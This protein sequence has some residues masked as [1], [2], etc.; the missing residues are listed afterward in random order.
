MSL[1]N[2]QREWEVFATLGKPGIGAVREVMRDHLLVHVEG[3]GE[4]PVTADQI[5]EAH[6]GKVMLDMDAL[7]DELRAAIAHAHDAEPR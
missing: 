5:S 7:N 2:I 1:S 6:D 3:Y 4:V